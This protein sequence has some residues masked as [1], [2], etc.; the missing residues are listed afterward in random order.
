MYLSRPGRL[1]DAGTASTGMTSP[2]LD[3][4]PGRG[5]DR[6]PVRSVRAHRQSESTAGGGRDHVP[7]AWWRHRRQDAYGGGAQPLHRLGRSRGRRCS[8]ARRCRPSSRAPTA[9]RSW[10]SARC[11]GRTGPGW[12][13]TTP[14]A[15]RRR[16]PNGRWP[17][18]RLAAP[19]TSNTYVL[20]ANVAAA[21]G[22]ARAH[23][24]L[25]RRRHGDARPAACSRAVAK[26]STSTPRFPDARGRR[27][28]TIV[29]SLAPAPVSLVVER[30]MYSDSS[31]QPW[32]AGTN[33]VG[34]PLGP[35]VGP[36]HRDDGTARRHRVE[37][38]CDGDR[39]GA[40]A[41]SRHDRAIVDGRR[42]H[43]C[44]LARRRPPRPT[45]T[46][47]R[48]DGELR[49]RRGGKVG[50]DRPGGRCRSRTRRDPGRR[51]RSCRRIHGGPPGDGPGHAHR[52]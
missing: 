21:A 43:D 22:T 16:P 50:A 40:E 34:T 46:T 25:R 33:A 32:A 19:T 49:R 37:R 38:R 3:V 35:I 47:R 4:V 20:I 10:S 44:V 36:G 51:P 7:A 41:G 27:F 52:R 26:R 24:L 42:P 6:R 14:P 18:A 45:T 30:A 15:R 8:P 12:K 2:A 28:G 17:K 29:E 31:G 1:F 5:R 9:C 23:A 48:R 13:R 11:G 39:A